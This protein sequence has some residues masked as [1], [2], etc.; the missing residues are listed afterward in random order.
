MATLLYTDG[1][2]PFCF[3]QVAEDGLPFE[4]W[5]GETL[6][7]ETVEYTIGYGDEAETYLDTRINP[8]KSGSAKITVYGEGTHYPIKL[9]LEQVSEMYWKWRKVKFEFSELGGWAEGSTISVSIDGGYSDGGVWVETSAHAETSLGSFSSVKPSTTLNRKKDSTLATDLVCKPIGFEASWSS[10]S[11]VTAFDAEKEVK[12]VKIGALARVNTSAGFGFYLNTD[13]LNIIQIGHD[14]FWFCPYEDV[15]IGTP[16]NYGIQGSYYVVG[17]CEGA[18]EMDYPNT[19]T[20]QAFAFMT[21][22]ASSYVYDSDRTKVGPLQ[23]IKIV[24]DDETEVTG[25]A[26][27]IIEFGEPQIFDKGEDYITFNIPPPDLPTLK[28][29]SGECW[30]Y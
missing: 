12:D 15:P 4:E 1:Y 5:D 8:S 13:F 20:I 2:F 28:I 6:H 7:T 16:R 19:G 24:F 23:P 10:G 9:T 27:T 21:S 30:T 26:F 14:E 29:S 17:Q 3:P 11:N 22:G 25:G 18:V